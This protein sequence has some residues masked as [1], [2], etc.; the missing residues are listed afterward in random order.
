MSWAQLN[1]YP[2][3]EMLAFLPFFALKV[4]NMHLEWPIIK[5]YCYFQI[6]DQ[7]DITGKAPKIGK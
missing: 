5:Y 2:I 4:R 3:N 6:I 7:L 1:L